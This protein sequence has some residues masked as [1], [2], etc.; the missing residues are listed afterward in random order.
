MKNEDLTVMPFDGISFGALHTELEL[1][2]SSQNK[3]FAKMKIQLV[4]LNIF[5]IFGKFGIDVFQFFRKYGIRNGKFIL[6]QVLRN[7]EV[8]N[9]FG[10]KT[11]I[12]DLNTNH[13]WPQNLF[14][15]PQ[16]ILFLALK[17]L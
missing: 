14:Y 13:F 2:Y 5:I 11:N 17:V 7:G 15:W 3:F 1:E 16:N 4:L 6:L 9:I 10:L 8:K 12:F